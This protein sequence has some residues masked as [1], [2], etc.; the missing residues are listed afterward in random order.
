MGGGDLTL[1]H[2]LIVYHERM[3]LR[4]PVRI[5]AKYDKSADNWSLR[6][7]PI[8]RYHW[9]VQEVGYTLHCTLFLGSGLGGQEGGCS[10]PPPAT[11]TESKHSNFVLLGTLSTHTTPSIIAR[12]VLVQGLALDHDPSH[13]AEACP[14]PIFPSFFPA[15]AGAGGGGG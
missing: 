8:F 2:P 10:P 12:A 3:L 15:L 9:F 7:V 5:P 4:P 13:C 11:T 14:T 6:G 1:A